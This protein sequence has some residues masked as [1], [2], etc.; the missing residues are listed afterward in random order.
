ML[1]SAVEKAARRWT[2]LYLDRGAF[3]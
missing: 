2:A 3:P 1:I